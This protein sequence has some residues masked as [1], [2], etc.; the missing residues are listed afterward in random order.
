MDSDGNNVRRLTSTCIDQPTS[1]VWSP[2]KKLIAFGCQLSDGS[3]NLCIINTEGEEI[4]SPDCEGEYTV[5]ID[6]AK[7]PSEFSNWYDIESLSWAA[8]GQQLAFTCPYRL[9]YDDYQYGTGAMVCIIALNGEL[10][11]WS[12]S[13]NGG[14]GEGVRVHGRTSVAW[15]PT[16]DRLALSFDLYDD[17]STNDKIYIV[18]P[19]GQNSAFLVEGRN[20]DW[21]PDGKQVAFFQSGLYVIDQDGSDLR[22]V[23][24]NPKHLDEVSDGLPG[25][26]TRPAWSPDGRFVVFAGTRSSSDGYGGNIYVVDFKTK[27]IERIT[28]LYDGHFNEPDWSP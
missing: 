9:Q 8:D 11:C 3:K 22:L 15:S 21:S 5:L 26:T 24:G 18:D 17:N 10:D 25:F 19:N 13:A 4:W 16:Q 20:P 2:D 14:A 23:R 27:E 6:P 7:V 28:E 1:P 12:V